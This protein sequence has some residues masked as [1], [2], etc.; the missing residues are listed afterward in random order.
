MSDMRFSKTALKPGNKIPNIEVYTN[1]RKS[2][3]LHDLVTKKALLII[4]G[5]LTCPM[6]I[7]SLPDLNA[8]EAEFG[9][10]ISFAL[11]YVREAHPGEKYTQPQTLEQKIANARI[12]SKSHTVNWPVIVDNINGTLHDSLDTKPNSVHL[13]NK[14][15]QILFQ[16]LWAGDSSP[17]KAALS[18]VEKNKS[19][20]KSISQKMMGPFIRSAGYMDE[21][22]KVAGRGAYSELALGAPPIA[23]LSKLSSVFQF[24]P[25]PIRGYAAMIIMLAAVIVGITTF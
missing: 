16:S 7:S 2:I 25:K 20:T 14:R 6:T 8:F 23:L 18:Q 24:L 19:V 4:T 10:D 3:Y 13:I 1:L 22:L 9:S 5:S 21:A 11:L 12:L 15:G 17:L